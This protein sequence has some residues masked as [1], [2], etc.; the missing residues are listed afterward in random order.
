ML[1]C[2][3]TGALR[4]LYHETPQLNW[5]E[6]DAL[7]T[8]ARVL[9]VEDDA[10]VRSVAVESLRDRGFEVVEASDGDIAIRYLEDQVSFRVLL[11]DVRMPSRL[12]GIDVAIHARTLDPEIQVVV[13]SGYAPQ[14]EDR[15]RALVPSAIFISKPYRPAKIVT[16][17][18]GL[19]YSSR[20]GAD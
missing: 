1:P 8:S 9:V 6:W 13:V 10:L 20:E 12:D 19:L 15:L 14:L 11:T 3:H 7:M 2:L 5:R 18:Q 4:S 17:V 16:A